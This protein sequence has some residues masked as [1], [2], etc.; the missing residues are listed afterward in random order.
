MVQNRAN[1]INTAKKSGCFGLVQGTIGRQG[2]PRIF[3]DLEEKLKIKNKVFLR[4]LLSEIFA[5]K[6]ALFTDVEW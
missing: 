2:N 5:N 1:A 3:D 4:V 6:L